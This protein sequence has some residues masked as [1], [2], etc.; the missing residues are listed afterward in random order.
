MVQ[1][2][3]EFTSRGHHGSLLGAFSSSGSDPL[4]IA[5]QVTIRAKRSQDVLGTTDQ[6]FANKPIAGFGNPQLG[7][8]IPGLVLS[9]SEPQIRSHLATSSKPM[10]I[11]EGQNKGQSC[12]RSHSSNLLKVLGVRILLLAQ[13]LY[14]SIV[15]ADLCGELLDHL[16]Q[17]LQSCLQ[18]TRN[19][20]LDPMG[21][22]LC[23]TTGKMLPEGFHRSSDMIDEPGSGPHQF[24]SGFNHRQVRLSGFAPMLNRIQQLGI[25]SA[26][27][28]QKLSILSVRFLSILADESNL[29][30]IGATIS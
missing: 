6:Q 28:S 22:S 12:D 15:L 30:G 27:T 18:A 3:G 8:P 20:E 24:I 7:I 10:G 19:V 25:H 2:D 21:K 11:L 5:S 29:S 1:Q 14:L 4:P 9:G 16:Q 17:G 13:L 23:G 26:Q